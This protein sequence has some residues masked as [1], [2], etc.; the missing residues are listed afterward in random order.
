[1]ERSI[2]PRRGYVVQGG[3]SYVSKQG[4]EYTPGVSAETVGAKALFLGVV[5]L[6]PGARTSS[7]VHERHESAFYMLSG[8]EVEWWTGDELQYR[9]VAHPGDYLFVPPNVPHV[10]VNRSKTVPAI[11]VGARNEPTAQES[12]VMRPDLNSKIA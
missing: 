9:E 2:D 1:M 3:K 4:P 7:H 10:A 5:T 8:E 11:F 12:V 6:A